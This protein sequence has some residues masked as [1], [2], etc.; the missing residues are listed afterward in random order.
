MKKQ[1]ILSALLALCL[2]FSLVPTALAAGADDFTD[3][4]K[5]S[6][7]Y[8]YVDY[9]T[10]K[11]YFLGTTGTTFSPDRNMTRAM[12][13]VVLARFDNVK[14][15]NSQSAFTD[16][17]PGSWCAGA[18]NWAAANKIVEGKGDGRFAPNEPITRAQMCAIMDRYLDYYTEKHN[19]TVAKKGTAATLKDQSQVP[20]YAAA[21]VRNCQ[22]YGL[23]YGYEDGTFRPQANSTRAHVAAIIYRLAFLVDDAKPNRG[24]GG[25]SDRD[26]NDDND[27]PTKYKYTLTFN[28][29]G[30]VFANGKETATAQ[31][32]ENTSSS[33]SVNPGAYVTAPTREGYTF[34]G[35]SA[36][37]S[38]TT[39]QT[40]VTIS[41]NTT[42]YAVWQENSPEIDPNDLVGQ[43][44]S[45]TVDQVNS[46]Y[47]T[48]KSA[49]IDAIKAVNDEHN[50]LTSEQLQKVENVIKEMVSVET[51]TY[52]NE[53]EGTRTVTASASL[54]VKEGQVV[55][56]IEKATEFASSL[57]DGTTS[58]P[59]TDDVH[60]FLAS[61]KNAVEEQTGII[62]TNQSL[63]QIKNQA[64][65][66]V[67]KEGKELW[68]NFYDE[69]G[70]Y[71]GD[72]T[73]TAGDASVTVDV[74]A[75]SGSTTLVGDKTTAAKKLGEAIAK[76]MYAQIREQSNGSYIDNAE[77]IGAVTV[78]FA[79]S[80][81]EEYAAKTFDGETPIFPN[82]YEVSLILKMDSD[83]LV[84]YKFDESADTRNFVCINVTKDIQ[85]AYNGALNEVAATITYNDETKSQVVDKVKEELEAHVGSL[86][87]EVKN[88]LEPYGIELVYTTEESLKNALLPKVEGWVNANWTQIV[89]STDGSGL[90]NLD[91]SDLIDAAWPLV[92]Q[93]IDA[94]NL[95]DTIEKL[96]E[97][98]LDEAGVD[99]E[100][101][102][103]AV[104]DAIRT[105]QNGAI[106]TFIDMGATFEPTI[107]V[108]NVQQIND[109][110]NCES[111]KAYTGALV[112][113]VTTNEDKFGDYIKEEVIAQAGDMLDEKLS[114]SETLSGIL[115]T[116]PEVKD[117]LLYSA[118]VQMDLDFDAEKETAAADGETLASLGNTIKTVAREKI[119][120]KLD[121]KLAT[122]DVTDYLES[123][124][125]DAEDYQA[126]IDL[127]NS[128]KFPN[129]QTKTAE[130]LA[131]ALNSQ[132]LANIVG[133][134]GDAYVAKY[135]SRY[136]AKIMNAL[137]AGASITICGVTLDRDD[138][139][140]LANADTDTTLEAVKA[141][142][143]IIEQFG[144][145]KLSDFA[146]EEGQIVTVRY[147][148]RTAT[149]H[150]VINIV[151]E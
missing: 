90:R 52:G 112:F 46:K 111:V 68:A 61:V 94:V 30:G 14:V 3:V 8:E 7:C 120:E 2:V 97:E 56:V 146:R 40:S 124:E 149:F 141:V 69:G 121:D 16:V 60:N 128:L 113:T 57:L 29:N 36:N 119:E 71:C 74:D 93:D 67:K 66:K 17:E 85:D 130:G 6:W 142:T 18:I 65:D 4:S 49:V 43:A 139:A 108:V 33:F 39:A 22:I 107:P 13:V 127:L 109:L 136:A 150:L 115:E 79:V 98:Q 148:G 15:N 105:Y 95:E 72:V 96:I 135:L 19:V 9:V 26:D 53:S 63:E 45:D 151:E 31:T 51:V 38:S 47:E 25:G 92:E 140:V 82:E 103:D 86:V 48:L 106:Q 42:F 132:T 101:I 88:Q 1:R 75:E 64:I 91:N 20:T 24:G 70:Y 44:V 78:T 138:L 11:G 126:K 114:G 62:L 84:E 118:L 102:V 80:D 23:I 131:N 5:D 21:A 73:I 41:G 99:E 35:W 77:L 125:E 137:P 50:Y 122:I 144:D 147:N 123:G 129:V 32:K 34:L 81:N 104:N 12:F 28:A 110:L 117:Y 89:A 54:D 37:K 87:T 143:D 10:S 27:S 100:W 59:S 58:T 55:S 83:G 133:T 145:L 116:N 134:K 76:A